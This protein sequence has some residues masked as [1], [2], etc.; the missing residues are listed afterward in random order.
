MD[1]NL[2]DE[3]IKQI[4]E[5]YPSHLT[6]KVRA[7]DKELYDYVSKNFEGEKFA[8]KLYRFM[9]GCEDSFCD[10][11]GCEDTVSFLSFTKGFKEFC[12]CSCG[13]KKEG[14]KESIECAYCEKKMDAYKCENKKYCSHECYIEHRNEKRDFNKQLNKAREAYREK[15]D[16]MGFGSN[17]IRK[18]IRNTMEE[19]YGDK[20]YVNV[21]K[22][23][24]TKKKKYGDPNYNNRK[25]KRQTCQE[26][27]NDPHYH[28]HEQTAETR[29]NSK[30]EEV[31]NDPRFSSVSPLFSKEEYD[32]AAGYIRYPFKC[33]EC[34][35]EF[36]DYLYSGNIPRCPNCYDGWNHV[37]SSEEEKTIA[38][39]VE[40]I[41]PKDQEVIKNDKSVLNGKE[42]DIYIPAKNIAVEYNGLYWHSENGGG[43]DKNYH[44]KKTEACEEAGIYLIHIFENEWIL[45][46]DVVKRKLA[47]IFK[48]SSD[49]TVHASSCKVESITKEVADTFL[50]EHH[51]RGSSRSTIN[52]GLF[53]ENELIGVMTFGRHSTEN[54][55]P[56]TIKRFAVSRRVVGAAEKLFNKF[57]RRK[58]PDKVITYV[59][60]R[61]SS[62][63][64]NVYE[65]IGFKLE[66]ITEP[67]YYYFEESS[68]QL[69]EQT[70]FKKEL[71]NDKLENFDPNL[72]EWENMQ[73]HNYDRIWDCG[74]LKYTWTKN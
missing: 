21:K 17:K 40:K 32:G 27:Y 43:K 9:Y 52:L 2:S 66:S 4:A 47:H 31:C 63:L 55:N 25:K 70:S 68:T 22:R 50:E 37:G 3:Q 30:Y 24:K 57:R 13:A 42:L 74:H 59:D 19:K 23:K 56:W 41:L 15:Y 10:M 12:S 26:K 62:K 11:S 58:E 45:K 36:E 14:S 49:E 51:L 20:F 44:L 8:E 39:F 67:D 71:L 73:R 69:Y 48:S 60:R 54:S 16:G 18:K 6:Q 46:R 33:N 65:N 35:E 28:N 1:P 29:K 7:Q 38:N 64:D 72:T 61:W 34:D 53:F 5:E